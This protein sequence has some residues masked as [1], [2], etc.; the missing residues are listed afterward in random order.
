MKRQIIALI[1]FCFVCSATYAGFDAGKLFGYSKTTTISN[2]VPANAVL[3]GN[4]YT[5]ATTTMSNWF[6]T[7]TYVLAMGIH[8]D[9]PGNGQN[10]TTHLNGNRYGASSG[11]NA[12]G[13][14][15]WSIDVYVNPVILGKETLTGTISYQTNAGSDIVWTDDIKFWLDEVNVSSKKTFGL[16]KW[17]KKADGSGT[18]NINMVF[19]TE[20]YSPKADGIY[21][22]S[23]DY[24]YLGFGV[25]NSIV[26]EVGSYVPTKDANPIPVVPAPAAL[27]LSGFGTIIISRLRRR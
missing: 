5:I 18:E 26:V 2:G 12:F 21:T 22:I 9:N 23:L 25:S 1:A 6:D 7:S 17:F 8:D 27:A 24:S 15:N 4:P 11:T 13:N 19:G 14:A 3:V 16:A 20:N 10:D